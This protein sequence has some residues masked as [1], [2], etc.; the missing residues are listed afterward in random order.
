MRS[1]AV[2]RGARG[3]EREGADPEDAAR[4]RG[5][6]GARCATRAPQWPQRARDGGGRPSARAGVTGR[7]TAE[8]PPP[9][10]AGCSRPASAGQKLGC[11]RRCGPGAQ[12]LCTAARRG[13]GGGTKPG[14][15]RARATRID[16]A[17]SGSPR[18]C[19]MDAAAADVA[20]PDIAAS[21]E[22][23]STDEGIRQLD[24]AAWEHA[25]KATAVAEALSSSPDTHADVRELLSQLGA[26]GHRE[27]IHSAPTDS[28]HA[29]HAK[30]ADAAARLSDAHD[31][32]RL[33]SN[34]RRRTFDMTGLTGS[35]AGRA[36]AAA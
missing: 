26:A 29:Q 2:P 10:R 12:R 15:W 8:G 4:A 33:L 13:R 17:A 19:A 23:S 6:G 35:G 22:P 14:G 5:R 27:T 21:V 18:R 9:A 32:R 28:A 31:V 36:G 16:S 1:H 30:A 34:Y 3:R 7:R 20:G 11:P 25:I 24:L